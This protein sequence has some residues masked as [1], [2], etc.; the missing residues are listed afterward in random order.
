MTTIAARSICRRPATAST[1][2]TARS[3]RRF[4]MASN[5]SVRT[6]GAANTRRGCSIAPT[7][8]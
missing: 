6:P 2:S 4:V 8:R 5:T 7:M 1:T 3:G